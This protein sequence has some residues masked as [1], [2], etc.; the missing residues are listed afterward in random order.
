MIVIIIQFS[1]QLPLF[2]YI[3][4]QILCLFIFH[5]TAPASIFTSLQSFYF[6]LYFTA[7]LLLIFILHCTVHTSIKSAMHR[8]YFYAYLIAQLLF[9]LILYY[10][11]PADILTSLNSFLLLFIADCT[12]PTYFSNYLDSREVHDDINFSSKSF[13]GLRMALNYNP[14]EKIYQ[15]LLSS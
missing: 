7:K 8:S 4:A 5:C 14:E 11:G 9:L 15:V 10:T 1:F 3:T 6:Y 2:S 12:G 13:L